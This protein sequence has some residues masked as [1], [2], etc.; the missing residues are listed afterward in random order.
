LIPARFDSSRFPGKAL[1]LLNGTP[2]AKLVYDKCK[3]SGLDTFIVS[4]DER[5][6]GLVEN[7]VMTSASCQNGT[8]RCAEAAAQL[9]GYDAFIN[10][11]GDM[12]DITTEI[13]HSV[14]AHLS[15]GQIVTAYTVMDDI[16]RSSPNTVK[17]IHNESIAHWF[18]RVPLKYG[19][20]H[21]GVYGY[22]RSCLLRYLELPSSIGEVTESLEQ[23][24]WLN[25][26]Y[27]IHVVE[28]NFDGV[29]INCPED[30]VIW[31]ARRRVASRENNV[32]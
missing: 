15:K 24:R 5:I 19:D 29:E 13:I 9:P 7:S 4:D 11:Q 31:E 14:V 10:V 22:S 30:L 21:L 8:E 20:Q 17:L 26:G 27:S 3:E 1:A 23:L 6:C 2:M 32:F 12:P 25:A 18:C 16:T 28:V